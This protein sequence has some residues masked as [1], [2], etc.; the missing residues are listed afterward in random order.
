ML[1]LPIY[2]DY[3][4]TTPVDP[5]VLEAMLPYFGPRFG[6][7]ASL[8]HIPGRAADAAV[9]TA[10]AEVAALIGA[11]PQEIVFTSGATESINLALKGVFE[12]YQSKGNHIITA[13]TEH[14]AVLDTCS[15]LERLG[16]GITRLMVN[17]SGH[18]DLAE[19]EQAIRPDTVLIALM[20]ANNETGV[21]N[22]VR[23]ISR[24]ARAGNV[25]FF[26]DA[27]QAAGKIPVDVQNDGVDLLAL[28]AHKFYGPKGA[29]ALYVRRRAPRM[30][31]SPQMDGGGHERGMRSG[32]LNVPGIVG[33]GRA[34]AV[35]AA[36]MEK[37][38]LWTVGL[39]DEFE[40][41]IMAVPGA[42][43]NGDVLQRLPHTSSI[44]FDGVDAEQV[45]LAL[46]TSLAMAT[47]SACTSASPEP[48]HVLLAMGLGEARAKSS[49]RIGFGRFS[50]KEELDFSVEKL[51]G[52]VGRLRA[53]S[54]ALFPDSQ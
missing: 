38:R 8:H 50:T 52:T 13:A 26:C 1:S 43:R 21:V 14:A 48:S 20:F 54:L 30:K 23:E 6:N 44:G 51:I 45:M 24:I 39:R 47:G 7:A 53:E 29:G 42:F 49:L 5:R 22:P 17:E 33:L 31:L 37:D 9:Q 15:H 46:Q 2:L 11:E 27:T 3:N 35:A 25:P 41:R 34:A 18:I 10:R 19:L 12:M 32:T 28:S 16:A 36:E 40:K 4:A